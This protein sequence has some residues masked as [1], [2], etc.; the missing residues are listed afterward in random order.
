MAR[1]RAWSE[2]LNYRSSSLPARFDPRRSASG[3]SA[4]PARSNRKVSA[5]VCM[6][7]LGSRE[8]PRCRQS[9][10]AL[11]NLRARRFELFRELQRCA[12]RLRR[13]IDGEAGDVSR[14][15][16]ENA[17]AFAIIDRPEV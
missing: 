14:D 2:R 7:T 15:L 8:M 16:E 10:Q 4:R 5:R 1:F 17:T 3:W 6:V 11:H 13:F 12:E 9:W